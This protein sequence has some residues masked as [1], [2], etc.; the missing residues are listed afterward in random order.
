MTNR[1]TSSSYAV[2]WR[3]GT[4]AAYPGKLEL[5]PDGI[6]LETGSRR[7]R[8]RV[9]ALRYEAVSAVRMARG[10]ERLVGRPTILLER[11]GR[12]PVAIS[13]V[14]GIGAL[15]DLADQINGRLRKGA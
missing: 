13:I 8:L 5:R 4:G 3:D 2:A 9:L 7:G 6:R 12:T 10:R 11:S 15:V 1:S 14:S